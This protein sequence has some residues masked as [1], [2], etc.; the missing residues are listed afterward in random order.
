MQLIFTLAVIADIIIIITLAKK[1]GNFLEKAEI[2]V[3]L[4]INMILLAWKE[5]NSLD[6]SPHNPTTLLLWI[7]E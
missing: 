1:K 7:S 5:N 2:L 6:P 3:S 4:K